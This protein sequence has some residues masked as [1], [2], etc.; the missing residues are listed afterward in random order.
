MTRRRILGARVVVH[1]AAR[2][3]GGERLLAADAA[4]S[5]YFELA[6]AA[7]AEF[8]VEVLYFVSMDTHAHWL[9]KGLGRAIAK[10]VHKCHGAFA[11]K[12]NLDLARTGHVFQSRYQARHVTNDRYLRRL[13][14]Y[15]AN[16]PTSA[17]LVATP[18][19]YPWSADP[20][21]RSGE[22]VIPV[23]T[24][25]LLAALGGPEGYA[26]LVDQPSGSNDVRTAIRNDL[27]QGS[28]QSGIAEPRVSRI[29]DPLVRRLRSQVA[30]KYLAQGA[31]PATVASALGVSTR[32]LYRLLAS[33]R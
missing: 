7:W 17:G 5:F 18:S 19:E 27:L 31:H 32:T 21:Y 8:E 28:I 10:A 29:S 12:C 4:K 9:V 33:S 3:Q 13:T 6:A 11:R 16:N 26:R 24:A 20:A 14:Y 2:F 1:V 25:L 15:L 23:D 22:A 30:R